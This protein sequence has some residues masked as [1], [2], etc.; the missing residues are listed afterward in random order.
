MAVD[1][2]FGS[3]AERR[4]LASAMLIESFEV[5]DGAFRRSRGV[6]ILLV[7][8]HVRQAWE[9]ADR[10]YVVNR[11]KVGLSGMAV[12]LMDRIDEIEST[13]LANAEFEAA[14]E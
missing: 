14:H 13:Y 3:S 7:E 12:E 9:M 4:S 2:S 5:Q 1:S 8:E 10:A 6:G 11:G